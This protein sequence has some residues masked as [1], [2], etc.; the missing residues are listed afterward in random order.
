MAD[1]I[2]DLTKNTLDNANAFQTLFKELEKSV[3]G[4]IDNKQAVKSLST[5]ILP[6]LGNN[7]KLIKSF[8][9]QFTPVTRLRNGMGELGLEQK[10]VS[11]ITRILVGEMK[12]QLRAEESLAKAQQTRRTKIEVLKARLKDMGATQKQVNSVLE[13]S[14]KAIDGD[15][16]ALDRLQRSYQKVSSSIKK[17][18]ANTKK[19]N[20]QRKKAQAKVGR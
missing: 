17:K 18:E 1:V 9:E 8:Q 4:L 14:K 10:D 15:A 5:S 3:K 12:K 6:L 20:A 13:H 11:L 2:L 16:V 19:L 7:D